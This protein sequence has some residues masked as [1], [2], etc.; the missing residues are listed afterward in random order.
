M[1][2]WIIDV[3]W[4]NQ[5]DESGAAKGLTKAQFDELIQKQTKV[6]GHFVIDAYMQYVA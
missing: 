6:G 4:K 3:E 2:E 5:S 1:S